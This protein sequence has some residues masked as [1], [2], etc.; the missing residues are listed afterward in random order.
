M[1]LIKAFTGAVG[2]GLADQWL[3]AY[4]ADNMT[5]QTVMTMGVPVR[6]DD[7]RSSN[8]KGTANVI[9]NGSIIQVYPNQF[10]ML[11]ENGK[12]IDYTAEP[13]AF[14]V[15]NSAMP[16]LFNGEFG[17]ALKETFSRFKFGG[18]T[19]MSQKA[20][21]IN[22]QEIKNIKFG[23]KTPIQYFDNFYNSEL[24]LRCFGNY[25]IEIVD[26][27]LFYQQV[28]DKSATRQMI[29]DINE[30][31]SAEFMNALSTS[32]NQM[33]ADGIRISFVTSKGMELAKYM[34]NVLDEAW[35]EDRG[36]TVKNV[37]IASISY[38]EESQELI[39]MRNK[40]AML[41]DPMVREG[42]VQG[43]IARGLEA[44]GSNPNGSAATFM[45]M[46]M[47]MN[48]GGG[49][50]G[51]A[52]QSN[53]QQYQQ[54]QQMAQQQQQQQQPQQAGQANAPAE[55]GAKGWFCPECGSKNNPNAKFCMECGTKRM[56]QAKP[57]C[58]NCG[59]E[60]PEGMDPKFC[61]S[62]GNKLK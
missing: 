9:S 59:W 47:G 7:K 32:M 40:G 20:I 50:M 49:F 42:Y 35:K 2:G 16:S 28:V 8:T 6:R 41:G 56:E 58:S 44:A 5:D 53:M 30:Q 15:D 12:I 43:S 37:G 10:M 27:I 52:S 17:D 13:G 36:F 29:E 4:E 45:G 34:S 61:P 60:I 22:L 26:P 46:G 14:K 23:T 48:A 3:E 18:T 38:S 62:C 54:Q 11:V 51:T 33:S 31:Y 25:S 39:N 1:G 55:G 21:F 24:F 57:K 19:P